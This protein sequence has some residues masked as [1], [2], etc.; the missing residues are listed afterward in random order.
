LT[1]E[2]INQVRATY[3]DLVQICE[4]DPF[5]KKAWEI[6]VP[7]NSSLQQRTYPWGIV[8][9]NA[10]MVRGR[11]VGTNVYVLDTG[12]RTTH[13]LFGG[14]AFPGVDFST[15]VL[16]VCSPTDTSCAADAYGHGTHCAGTVGATTYGVADGATLWAMKVLSDLGSGFVW[17]FV[18]TQQ[19]ILTNGIRPAV[20]SMSLGGSHQLTSEQVSIDSLVNDGITVV[21]AAGNDNTDACTFAPAWIP[22]AITVAS[23]Q[24]GGGKSSFSNYGTCVDVWAPGSGIMSLG[25][26]DDSGL[27]LNSGT[28]MACPHV[29]GLAAIMYQHHAMAGTMTASQRWDLLTGSQRTGYVTGIPTTPVSVNLVALAPTSAPATPAPTDGVAA[30]GDPHLQNVHGE[31][32]DL[33]KPG[34]HVMLNIPRGMSPENTLLRVQADAVRLGEHCADMYFRQLNITGSWA[35]AKQVGGYQYVAS[36]QAANPPEWIAVGP[37]FREVKLKVVHGITEGGFTYLN[38]YV[39]NLGRVGLAVGGLLGEDDHTDVS[40]PSKHCGRELTLA[41]ER[42]QGAN[43]HG[44]SVTSVAAASLD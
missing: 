26:L 43:V 23:Y 30:V 8:D 32:F 44:P 42:A 18:D 19:W 13:S 28:S 10:N 35:E 16:D 2:G 4:E 7:V 11:G 24:T 1:D 14:R 39:K 41:D 27:A 3:S 20:V 22:S 6:P 37:M 38:L 29:S 25:V 40:T 34:N 21:V 36:Q 5:V 15:G 31:R 17:W 9:I 33:M 12:V